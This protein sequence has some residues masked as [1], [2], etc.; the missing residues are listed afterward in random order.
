MTAY[1]I[2]ERKKKKKNL[3]FE[4]VKQRRFAGII[5]AQE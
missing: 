2:S 4:H 3:I 5:K 1:Q